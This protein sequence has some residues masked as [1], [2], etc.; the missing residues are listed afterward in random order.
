MA[1]RR[2]PAVYNIPLHR[3][4]ADALVAGV[5]ASHGQDRMAMARGMILV[6]NNRAGLSIR[7]AFVRQS[8]GGLLLPRIVSVGD[9]ESDEAAGLAFDA[10]DAS[11]IPPAIDPLQRQLILARLIQQQAAF[12][13]RMP[14]N[15][16]M[17]LAADLGRV[18]DQLLI[19][20]IAPDALRDVA[21]GDLS[22]HWQ[23]SLATLT[24]ILDAWPKELARL[25]RIDL[26][27][28]RNRQLAQTA[29]LWRVTPP[30][31]FVI[32][33]GVSTV[34]PAIADLLKVIAFMPRGQV[35]LA[36]LDQAMPDDE[37]RAIGGGETLAAIE[38][39]PQ[40]HLSLLLDRMGVARPEVRLWRW[41]GDADA[42]AAR[43][44]AIS[45]A[46]A[47]AYATRKWV[48]LDRKDRDLSGVRAVE[49]AT[50]ADEAQGIA[51]LLRAALEEPGKTA[52]LVTPDR[53]LAIR[54]SA[55]LKRWGID[56]DDS[57]G[58]PLSA[59]PPGTLILALAEAVAQRFAPVALLGLLK[60]PLVN[61]GE[62]RLVWLDGVRLLD[63]ALRGPRPAEG[64][65]GLRAYLAS[66]DAREVRI[67]APALDWW[68]G[69]EPIMAALEGGFA[70]SSLDLADVLACLR[71]ALAALG[72][73][74]PWQGAAGRAAADLFERLER[75]VALGPADVSVAAIPLI[76][77]ALMDGVAVR[78]PNGGHPRL[79]IWG[80]I[81]ARLQSAQTV[82]LGG[83]NEGVWPALPAPDPWLAPQIRKLLGLPGL[84]RRIGLAAH[85]LGGGLGAPE[86]ILTRAKRDAS[87]PTIASRFWL[88]LDAMSGGLAP[89]K[90]SVA[91]LAQQIDRPAGPPQRA[92]QPAP[93]PPLSARPQS[94]AVTAV[95][96]LKADPFAF[97][98][99]SILK[100]LRWD[101]LDAKPGAAWRGS[102]IHRV[103]QDWAEQDDYR[104]DAL[105]PR[106]TA[107]FAQPDMH[108]L[109]RSLWQP[110]LIEAAD[111][112]AAE[113]AQ[114]RAQGRVPIAAEQKGV[115]EIDGMTI[116]GRV[117]RIDRMGDGSLAI[118]DYKSGTAPSGKQIVAGYAL[119]LGLMGLM[120]EMEGFAHVKGI[121][122]TFE[123]WMLSRDS[124]TRG[125][126][127]VQSA[128]GKQSG[129][130]PADL[131]AATLDHFKEVAARWLTGTAPFTA[132]L[133][134]EY[135]PYADYDQ[136]MRL[137]EWL[138][139]E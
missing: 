43:T 39:H 109:L 8:D 90:L 102:I 55:H 59:T 88:R 119:Q 64:L 87:A 86:A 41:G 18:V 28:R 20:Q 75:D 1:E 82:V 122:G 14:A 77:R 48:T 127:K 132:K 52:A 17:R 58:Q 94:I 91:E 31:G 67:R 32:A 128:L 100:L 70:G 6:P 115:C 79:F 30:A 47:P 9:V 42:R 71:D 12:T 44:R 83:L 138:D 25:G 51:I 21:Q 99:Q 33:A 35:V 3:A 16:A 5:L 22:V 139:R 19:E 118:I 105:R 56:A 126:G 103:L 34:A 93:C 7:D 134:P 65:S 123:Y 69:V 63:Q 137:E 45:N 74:A 85:D 110:R 15:E 50:P 23:A 131:T 114:G 97:Y 2:A 10:A 72:G 26:A 95:D 24:I 40:H 92:S 29:E 130:D 113:V 125:F 135:A 60:H 84:E 46:M 37:W 111:F 78:P 120:A 80:L 38:T 107:L 54:V 11:P 81:E 13:G 96:R 61:S 108:P 49:F 136:L 98:A 66:G 106:V 129:I 89:T 124:K 112:I 117:D 121:A 68:R 133:H 53:N 116:T 36:G 104:A 73:D 76:L 57:A 101:P 4:F 62:E 27:D